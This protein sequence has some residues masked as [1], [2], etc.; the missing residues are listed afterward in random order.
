MLKLSWSTTTREDLVRR[1]ESAEDHDRSG[2][3]EKQ[4]FTPVTK[5]AAL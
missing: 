1:R 5:G 3:E 4:D 2:K